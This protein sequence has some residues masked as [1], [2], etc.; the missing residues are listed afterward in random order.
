M[1]GAKAV[2]QQT[3]NQKTKRYAITFYDEA[4]LEGLSFHEVSFLKLAL[5]ILQ[6]WQQIV[7][8]RAF[9]FE[10]VSVEGRQC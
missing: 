4:A 8:M 5:Y 1:N 9:S 10:K 6:V 3:R 7:F 2:R